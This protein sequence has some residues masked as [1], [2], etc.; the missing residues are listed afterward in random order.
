MRVAIVERL[1]D[2]PGL[3]AEVSAARYGAI[4]T[5]IG[6]VRDVN[7]GRAVAALEYSA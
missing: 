4:A 3:I 5:F 1:I 7:D 6:T 2:V